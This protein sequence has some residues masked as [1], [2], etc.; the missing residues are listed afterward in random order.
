MPHA[1]DGGCFC[2]EIRY[3]AKSVF[4]SGYCHCSMCRRFSGGAA[5][6]WF[7]VPEHDFSLISGAPRAFQ[8]SATFA[9]HFCLTCGTHVFGRD[10]RVASPNVGFR[11]ISVAIGTLDDPDKV[12]PQLHQWWENRVV[13][14]A[15]HAA[16]PRFEDGGLTHP[17]KRVPREP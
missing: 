4:D 17:S 9:R 3:S 13:W 7:S 15:D 6:T 12:R 2:G 8:S 1:Y 16:L 10:S 14:F 11:L 5:F